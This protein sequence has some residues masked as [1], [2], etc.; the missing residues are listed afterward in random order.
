MQTPHMET[1]YTDY[2]SNVVTALAVNKLL[3]GELS[4]DIKNHLTS[5]NQQVTTD[6]IRIGVARGFFL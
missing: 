2:S 4:Q 1:V 3:A 5:L 6:V